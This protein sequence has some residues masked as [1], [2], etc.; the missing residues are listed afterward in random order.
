MEGGGIR[1]ERRSFDLWTDGLMT[2]RLGGVQC[3]GSRLPEVPRR[4]SVVTSPVAHQW[5]GSALKLSFIL[6]KKDF[7][8]S[9][10]ISLAYNQSWLHLRLFKEVLKKKKRVTF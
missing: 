2:D 9:V 8:I 10:R 5:V 6:E 1:D 7:F 3:A 4:V